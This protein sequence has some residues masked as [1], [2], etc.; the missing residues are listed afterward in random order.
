MFSHPTKD[1]DGESRGVHELFLLFIA[2][3]WVRLHSGAP[4]LSDIAQ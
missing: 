2:C 4:Q 1:V 3:M